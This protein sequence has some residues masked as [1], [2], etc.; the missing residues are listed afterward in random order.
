MGCWLVQSIMMDMGMG[1]CGHT[2][3]W[4][5]YLYNWPWQRG[6]VDLLDPVRVP[7]Y[8]R[9]TLLVVEI[10]HTCSHNLMEL[11]VGCIPK[12]TNR[13]TYY[14]ICIFIERTLCHV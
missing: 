13:A 8:H 10:F 11:G 6:L 14:L 9:F 2:A 5:S 1:S 4:G 3:C 12:C 7:F